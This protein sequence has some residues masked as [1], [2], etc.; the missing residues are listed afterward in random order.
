MKQAGFSPHP[1][2]CLVTFLQSSTCVTI[3]RGPGC[4][5]NFDQTEFHI[6]MYMKFRP[7]PF[8]YH[9]GIFS[10][11]VSFK[12]LLHQLSFLSAISSASPPSLFFPS[13]PTCPIRSLHLSTTRIETNCCSYFSPLCLAVNL[14]LNR[15]QQML[16]Q[17]SFSHC[18]K[19]PCIIASFYC[20]PGFPQCK[21]RCT[22]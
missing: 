11:P 5:P 12:I 13:Q 3:Q 14:A 22:V 6:Q 10:L 18:T 7:H 19:L 4:M 17:N 8:H 2:F 16:F 21:L 20:F 15:P 1:P 9:L